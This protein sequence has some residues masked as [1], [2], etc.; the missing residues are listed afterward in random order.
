MYDIAVIILLMG[1]QGSGKTTV[2]RAL[3]ARLKW[4]FAD[5]DDF[6]PPENIAKMSAGIALTDE[7]RAPWLAALR[8][9]IDRSVSEKQNLVL[10]CSALKEKYRQQLVISG[11][12]LVYL[13]GSRDLIAARL[14]SRTMHFAKLNL[15]ESQ[16]QQLEEPQN[17]LVVDIEHPV[18]E[19]VKQIM[20]SIGL[21]RDEERK[22]C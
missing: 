10:T 9:E 3:A 7:D 6:H 1:V 20:L 11:V 18:D 15:L 4:R 19:V 22:D 12:A 8:R 16:F 14:Q 17:A 5:A 21:Q 2:G 13:R